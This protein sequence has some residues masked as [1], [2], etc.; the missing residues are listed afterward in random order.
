MIT[1]VGVTLSTLCSPA[2][3]LCHTV[4][5]QV[6]KPSPQA[7]TLP[8]GPVQ[9]AATT[10]ILRTSALILIWAPTTHQDDPGGVQHHLQYSRSHNTKQ[11]PKS[12]RKC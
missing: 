6:L 11:E 1:L 12:P 2:A 4:P 3:Q 7:K 5:L 10:A 8:A 9:P